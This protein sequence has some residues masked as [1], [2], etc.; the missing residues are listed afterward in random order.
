MQA[1]VVTEPGGPEVFEI[2]EVP[3]PTPGPEDALVS[4]HATALNRADLLQRMGRYPG[5]AG[6][7]DDIPG[8]EMAGIVES[9]GERVTAWKPGDRVMALLGGGGYGGKVTVHERL[10][11]PVPP[12]LELED[13]AAIPEVYLT[14]YDALFM[15]CELAMGERVLIHAAGSGVGTAGIQ[16]AAAQGCRI[17][18][19]A[20][21]AEKLERAAELG[22]NVGIDYH[23]ADFAEVIAERTEG[24]GVHVVLDVIGASYGSRTSAR[25]A[26]GG[27]W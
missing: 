24:A 3:D 12:N 18:G 9:V 17:F 14:A 6:T 2:Q 25:S 15:Q 23:D 11:M 27:G 8:L 16:L 1:A 10:L 26:C 19:T 21:S 20:G 4:V 22:L 5:P 13:A 7:R